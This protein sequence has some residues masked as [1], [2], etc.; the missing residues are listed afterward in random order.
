MY[1]ANNDIVWRILEDSPI[2]HKILQIQRNRDTPFLLLL[3]HKYFI[4]VGGLYPTDYTEAMSMLV[5]ITQ[6]G[7]MKGQLEF[8]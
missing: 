6:Q 7:A 4:I 1:K 2:I 8:L 5:L 3:A